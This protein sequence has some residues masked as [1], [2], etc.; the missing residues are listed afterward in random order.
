MVRWLSHGDIV[1]CGSNGAFYSLACHRCRNGSGGNDSDVV[2]LVEP[3]RQGSKT[4]TLLLILH[5]ESIM[6]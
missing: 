5:E 6:V 4:E 1:V 2:L 3:S